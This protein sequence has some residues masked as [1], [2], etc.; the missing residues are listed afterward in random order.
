MPLA[1]ELKLNVSKAAEYYQDDGRLRESRRNIVISEKRISEALV[2]QRRAGLSSAEC[3]G[4]Y[5]T[6]SS[7]YHI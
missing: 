6:I 7:S 1:I 3:L 2:E 5:F 4:A